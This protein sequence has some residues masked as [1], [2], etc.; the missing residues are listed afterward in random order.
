M[1][2]NITKDLTPTYGSVQKLHQRDTDLVTLCEDKTLKVLA[3][4]DALFNADDTK[5]IT[6]TQNV[7]GNTIPFVGDYG[8]S[9]NPESFASD[10]YRSYFTDRERG[11]V[12][13]LSRDGLTPISDV[14]M[15]DWFSDNLIHPGNR[16]LRARK[17][18]GSYDTKR[19]LYNISGRYLR[20]DSPASLNNRTHFTV[21]YSEEAKGWVSFKTFTPEIALSL[22]NDY[23]EGF[24]GMLWRHHDGDADRNS[25]YQIEGLINAR[26]Y[27][28]VL[29]NDLP[30]VIKSFN[31][32]N[33]EGSQAKVVQNLTDRKYYNKKN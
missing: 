20:I 29:F 6:A 14:G 2:E 15:K 4:K 22:N 1:A 24:A 28:T 23:Y 33:Y 25:F 13:R 11:V 19:S 30:S 12:L 27:I 3:N 32:L 9:K 16:T 8:I 17:L 26:S 21:S 10:A 31:T 5:N 7:L 18:I